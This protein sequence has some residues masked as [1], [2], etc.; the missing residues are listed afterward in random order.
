MEL[1]R[2]GSDTW[3]QAR[4]RAREGRQTGRLCGREITGMF[5]LAQL[6]ETFASPRGVSTPSHCRHIH[7]TFGA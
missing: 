7:A 5:A 2:K 3:R 6:S 4:I 1:T